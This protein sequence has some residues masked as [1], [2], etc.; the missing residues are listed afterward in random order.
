MSFNIRYSLFALVGVSLSIFLSIW[1]VDD[2]FASKY[3]YKAQMSG[4]N[5]VPPVQSNATGLAEFTVAEN[6]TMKYRINATG[7]SEATGITSAHIYSGD[8][9]NN[10]EVVADLWKTPQSKDKDTAYGVIFRG[11]VTDSFLKGPLQGKTLDDLMALMDSGDAY[12]NIHTATNPDGEIRGQLNN[13][14][15]APESTNSSAGFST[16]TE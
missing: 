5:E 13:V 16:L 11:N 1:L 4:Q 14:D 2:A 9:G 3:P 6:S 7:I 10:G 8:E 15:V 12:V